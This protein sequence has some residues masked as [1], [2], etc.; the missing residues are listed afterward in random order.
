MKILTKT[1]KNMKSQ[2]CKTQKLNIKK[3]SKNE[4][5]YK[6]KTLKDIYRCVS[7]DEEGYFVKTFND[8]IFF[9]LQHTVSHPISG[10]F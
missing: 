5:I 2:F 7:N 8:L 6:K 9:L 4:K 3:K 1:K 10:T